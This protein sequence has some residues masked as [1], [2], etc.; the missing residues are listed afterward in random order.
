M[1]G[2]PSALK[3]AESARKK[4]RTSTQSTTHCLDDLLQRLDKARAALAGSTAGIDGQAVVQEA[5]RGLAAHSEVSTAT[6]ELHNSVSKLGKVRHR[7]MPASTRACY[8][9]A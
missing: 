9:F 1:D 4:Q 5:A 7:Q 8:D 3:E 6:K 2:L